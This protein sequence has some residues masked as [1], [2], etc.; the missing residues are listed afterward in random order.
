[1]PHKV[2]SLNT[3]KVVL[4]LDPN[5]ISD[6]RT[7]KPTPAI[8]VHAKPD[9]PLNKSFLTPTILPR[10]SP[11]G[12]DSSISE[13]ESITF[14][15][16]KPGMLLRPAHVRKPSSTKPDSQKMSTAVESGSFGDIKRELSCMKELDSQTLP[17]SSDGAR[18]SVGEKDSD[19]KTVTEKL[20]KVISPEKPSIEENSKS[21][22]L[23]C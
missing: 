8:E 12:K 4:P 20:E 3:P 5:K 11:A 16:T 9:E 1:M 23:C 7:E 19:I 13:R 14:S 2:G 17:L 10:E 21:L 15:R 6:L 18:N 22:I